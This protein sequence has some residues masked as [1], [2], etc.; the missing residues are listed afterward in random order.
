AFSGDHVTDTANCATDVTHVPGI[1]VEKTCPAKALVGDKLV[2]T[3]T[4]TNTGNEPLTNIT[5][6]DSIAGDVSDQFA[7][8]L[9]VGASET[10]TITHTATT[11]DVGNLENDVTASGT[12][13][14]STVTAKAA[15]GCSTAVKAPAIAFTGSDVGGRGL[16]TLL[17]LLAGGLGFLLLGRQPQLAFAGSHRMSRRGAHAAQGRGLAWIT[18]VA[19]HR[20]AHR[21]RH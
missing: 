19:P 5:V 14:D 3:I 21:K 15:T 1:A 17:L 2:Y 7:D 11:A 20:G 9:D 13:A 10:E 12:G 4:I 8:T 16:S 18:L 6:I